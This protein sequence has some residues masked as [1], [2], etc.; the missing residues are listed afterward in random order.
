MKVNS[1]FRGDWM[2]DFDKYV[3]DMLDDGLSVLIY[4]KSS[5]GAY[6][7]LS[8]YCSFPYYRTFANLLF[9]HF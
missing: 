8:S 1:D 7:H 6:S 9:F 5:S 4:G 2:K 3:G